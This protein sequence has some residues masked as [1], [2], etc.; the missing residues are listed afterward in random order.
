MRRL[1]GARGPRREQARRRPKRRGQPARRFHD[2]RLRPRAGLPRRYL[3]RRRSCRL[4]GLARRCERRCRRL[5]RQRASQVRRRPHGVANQ[6]AGGR[7]LC[8]ANPP[9]HLDRIPYPTV[10]HRHGAHAWLAAAQHFH[11]PYPQHDARPHRAR[12]THPHHL[13]QR[14]VLYQWLQITRARRAHHGRPHRRRGH[15]VHRL[16]ALLHVH[17]G[18]PANR[19]SGARGHDDRHGQSVF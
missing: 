16:V 13:C 8:H 15:R 9:H 17:H 10:L 11:R 4:L 12:P 6:K 19:R 2:G 14:R 1:P 5:K 7:C 18:R 3:H